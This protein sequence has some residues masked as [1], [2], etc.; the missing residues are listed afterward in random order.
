MSSVIFVFSDEKQIS[1]QEKLMY[2]RKNNIFPI[3]SSVKFEKKENMNSEFAICAIGKMLDWNI[4]S[5]NS[6]KFTDVRK[7]AIPYV[8]YARLNSITNGIEENKFGVNSLDT[9]RL[10]TLFL[11]SIGFDKDDVY[12]NSEKYIKD[13][14]LELEIQDNVTVENFVN[15]AYEMM[16]NGA[17]LEKLKSVI[18]HTSKF[19][20]IQNKNHK[21]PA[22]LTLPKKNTD[23]KYPIVVM[24]H[25]TGSN[26][27]EAGNGYKMLS[28]KL[29]AQGIA[30]I[31]FDFI[32]T[33]D[34]E[35]DYIEYNLKTAVSDTNKVIEYAMNLNQI[36]QEKIGLLGW[37][38]GGTVSLL[39][40]ASNT[41]VKTVVTW[42]GAIDLSEGL[43]TDEGYKKAKE[44]GYSILEFGWRPE[45]KLALEWYED[46]LNTDVLKEF[47]KSNASIL[48][49][50]GT[51]DDVV[52]PENAIKIAKASKNSE[53][54]YV[55]IED[56]D[57]TYRIF[58]G[59][60]EKYT[61]LSD[62]T[63]KW[64]VEKLKD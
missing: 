50:N 34:S 24:N 52:L 1:F 47:S 11:S 56:A 26:K 62:L 44:N 21:I 17:K 6:T 19:V 10:V 60:L 29:A 51:D 61:E 43:I 5:F 58:T 39:T 9:K 14:D 7:F 40:A 45:V 64:F 32:G 46:V 59:N 28:S 20:W 48:A 33:G 36:N 4:S 49:I 12:S 42:A 55:L 3:V 31:R 27:D 41:R 30:S 37:S 22:I 2:L 15:F 57:H 54:K 53:S 63:V 23:K 8:E 25:G 16:D 18:P 35:T 38:Q 13:Y